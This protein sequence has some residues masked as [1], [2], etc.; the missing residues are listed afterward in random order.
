MSKIVLFKDMVLE[1]PNRYRQKIQGSEDKIVTLTM[2]P[3]TVHEQGTKEKSEYFNEIQR[4]CLYSIEGQRIVD[5]GKDVYTASIQG[6][7]EFIQSLG[8]FPANLLI[9]FNETN[10]YENPLL[11]LGTYEF[12]FVNV[13]PASIEPYTVY[14][15]K[16]DFQGQRIIPID[17]IG[18]VRAEGQNWVNQI[19]TTGTAKLNAINARGLEI[20]NLMNT[21]SAEKLK[22]IEEYALGWKTGGDAL[23]RGPEFGTLTGAQTAYHLEWMIRSLGDALQT[24]SVIVSKEAGSSTPLLAT[25]KNKLDLVAT[26]TVGKSA[27]APSPTLDTVITK[28]EF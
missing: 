3:G 5:T 17:Q 13:L 16:L 25:S 26:I 4:N 18:N 27:T 21:T 20:L 6:L 12:R 10:R 9:Q 22:E 28:E 1:Y 19:I 23:Q 7:P 11:R 8:E 15:Y 14:L 24:R 2:E